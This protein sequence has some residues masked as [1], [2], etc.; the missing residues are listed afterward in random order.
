VHTLHIP[1][2]QPDFYEGPQ[3]G[4]LRDILDRLPSLQALIVSNL[5]FFD[6]QA[7][8]TIHQCTEPANYPLR[9]LIASSCEN[10]TA[11]SLA[12]ALCHFPDLIYLDLSSSQGARSPHVLRQIGAL[13]ELRIL[14]LR[15]CGLR[16]DDIDYLT[17]TPRLRSLDVSKNFLTERGLS[18]IIDRLPPAN[19]PYRRSEV[20]SPLSRRYSGVPLPAKV[21]A[22]GLEDY[23]AKRLTSGLDG[24]LIIEEGLPSTFTHLWLASNYITI[25][26]TNK[27]LNYPSLQQLDCGALN[28]SQKP[29]ELLSPSSPRAVSRRFS[30]PPPEIEVLSPGL[31]THAFRNLRSLRIHHSVITS[32]PFSGEEVAALEEQ[33]FEL[34]SEDLRFELDSTEVFKPGTIF[35]LDDTSVTLVDEPEELVSPLDPPEE[36]ATFE[37]PDDV[38]GEVE[39][40]SPIT[41]LRNSSNKSE[42]RP[43]PQRSFSIPRKA[44]PPRIS[45]SAHT[46]HVPIRHATLPTA[47]S[48]PLGPETFRYNYRAGEEKHWH[49]ALSNRHKPTTLKDLIEEISQRRH[50]TEARER[51]PGRFKPSMLPNLKTLTLTDVP[52]TT[53][54]RHFAESLSLFIQE[55]AEE[56]ELARLEELAHYQDVN[57]IPQWDHYTP[58][59]TLRLQRIV[60]EMTS[61]AEP[62]APPRSPRH[63][64]ESFTKSSTEDPD[65]ELFMQE[66][67]SDFSFFGEDDG[68]LLV[69][70]GRIDREIAVDGGLIWDRGEVHAID[71]VGELSC[72]RRERKRAFEYK[73]RFG[74]RNG[75][76][77]A[78]IGHWSGEVKV[79][80]EVFCGA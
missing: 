28:L 46:N 34:H 44:I 24:H 1:P 17:F 49:D 45:I 51:H 80:K 32:H 35:E 69:S 16:D 22:D 63:K 14:K 75:V 39:P 3:A 60:L 73:E 10:T 12:S 36:H 30:H 2:A 42:R 61:H 8:Q 18:K 62:L 33:C 56:E 31:F 23:V 37:S 50:R 41:I 53:H 59:S 64:R 29:T 68:G 26:E 78:L 19:L 48:V 65:S 74:R 79:V 72:W 76:E 5:A 25:D 15:N 52:S 58:Q 4:W 71:V 6:H 11:S 66:S 20:P 70:E 13:N 57:Q 7:L 43:E 38:G 77:S 40:T 54:R 55:C 21:L 67:Q 27:L 47:N 9:L